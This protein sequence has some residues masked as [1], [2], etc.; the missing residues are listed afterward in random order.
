MTQLRAAGQAAP[1]LALVAEPARHGIH[2]AGG[3]A[4]TKGLQLVAE[5]RGQG[6]EGHEGEVALVAADVED[7][8]VAAL[9]RVELCARSACMHACMHASPCAR[10][11]CILPTGIKAIPFGCVGNGDGGACSAC[12][13]R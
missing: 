9:A 8:R 7:G 4:V 11:L 10:G 5:R 6:V 3:V 13:S 1:H 12:S 2:A